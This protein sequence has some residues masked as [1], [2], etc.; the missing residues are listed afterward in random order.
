MAEGFT[1]SHSPSQLVWSKGW[2][3]AT[4]KIHFHL[5][6]SIFRSFKDHSLT[7]PFHNLFD[8]KKITAVFLKILS[9]HALYILLN[10]SE[11]NNSEPTA[12]L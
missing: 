10:C 11:Q 3:S 1:G 4:S 12:L 8:I 7:F 2:Y 6:V 9:M 5:P